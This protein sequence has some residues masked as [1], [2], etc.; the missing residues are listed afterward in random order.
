MK[1][2]DFPYCGVELL[3][4]AAMPDGSAAPI[5]CT[6]GIHGPDVMHWNEELGTRWGPKGARDPWRAAA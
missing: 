1:P 6:T 2:D 3:P 4:H 5:V